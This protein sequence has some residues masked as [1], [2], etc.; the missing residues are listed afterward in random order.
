VWQ[1]LLQA[2]RILEHLSLGTDADPLAV[3]A[4]GDVLRLGALAGRSNG[5]LVA[6]ERPQP[7]IVDLAQSRR[8]PS[9]QAGAGGT[10]LP[11]T[12]GRLTARIDMARGGRYG[13]WLGGSFRDRVRLLVDGR[14]VGAATHELEETAQLTPL[15]SASLAAG[16]HRVEVRYDGRGLRPGSRGAPFPLGPLAIGSPAAASR[17]VRVPA[18]G[19]G[20]LCGRRLDWIEAVG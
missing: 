8:P 16:G 4:C 13:F 11:T 2:E 3:P 19:A 5:S 18:A 17:L 14:P 1:R 10:V 7:E 20:S 12:S 15:G 9:W 6:A